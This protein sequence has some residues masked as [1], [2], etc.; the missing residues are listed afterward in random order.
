MFGGFSAP[1][2]RRPVATT[3]IMVAIFLVGLVAYPNLAVAPLPQVDFPTISVAASL[4][5]ASPETMAASVAQPLERQIAQIPG[6][7]QMTSTSGLGV[8]GITVQFDLNRNI[9]A[10]ANDIQAAI[11]AASGQLPKDLPSPPTYRKVNPSDTPILILSVQSDLKPIIDVDD[12]AENI[13]AQRISQISGVSLVRVGGQQTPAIRIQVDPAKLVE[14]GLQLED[15]RQQ[16]GIATVDSPKGALIGPRQTFTIYDNDQ[17]TAAKPWNDVIIAYRNGAPV[18]VRDIGRAVAGP[19]DTTQA[20]WSNGKSGV[21]LAIW[22]QPGANVIQTVEAVKKALGP[23]QAAIPTTIH[24]QILSDR[25]LTIRASVRDVQFTLMLTVGLVVMVIFIFLRNVWATVIPA[26]TIPL[27][28]LGACALMWAVGYSLDNLSLM[29]FTI[30]VGFVVDDA[31]VMLENITR[32]I[33]EGETPLQAA[34]KGSSEIGFTIISISVSLVAVLIP[35]IMM[36]GI[37]GR[38]FR[39]FSV[40]ITMTIAVSAFVALTLTPM[41][42]SRFLRS[43]DEERH[44]RLFNLGE[45]GFRALAHGYEH[46]LDFV[47]RHRFVTLMTFFA[48]VLATVYLFVA[49]PKGFFPQQD[50]GILYG[51]TEAAQDI[52]FPKMYRLQEEAGKIVQADPAVAAVGMGLGAGVGSTG[53]N[54]GRMFISLKPTDERNV[55]IFEVIARLRPKLA[56]IS[57]LRTYL[58]AAQDVTVGARF[59]KTQFQYTLLDVNLDELNAWAPKILDKLKSLPELRD[60]ATDQQNTGTTLTLKIDRDMASR[61]GIQPQLIDDT[62]YDAFGQREVAQYFTQVNTYWVVEEVLPSLRGDPA[63]L[64]K[65]YI[66]SPTT[67]QMVPLSVFAKWTTNPVAPLSISHQ[68]QFPAITISFNLANGVALSQ[69]TTAVQQAVQ[70]LQLPPSLTTTFQ[71]NAQAF[72]ELLTTVP[73]LILAALVCVYIILGILYESFVHPLTILSTLPSAGVGALATLM[74]FGYEFS[75]VALIGLILL[76]GIVKKN[77]IMMVDFAIAAEREEGK[78]T[79]EAIREAALLR[80]RPIMMTTMAALLGAVPLMLSHGSGSEMRQPLGFTMFGGL[81][82]SQA[83]TLFTTP[84]IYLYLD[85]VSHWLSR[86]SGKTRPPTPKRPVDMPPEERERDSRLKPVRVEGRGRAAERP[87]RGLH[88]V[89]LR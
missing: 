33:E 69:A 30:A 88:D 35:L 49:I 19:A 17:L 45:K 27:A 87:T 22:K 62:L 11:N 15:V 61:F 46:G 89:K 77:G 70:Q 9:D 81:I 82:F 83:L 8:T 43:Q 39:E 25:T 31:I 7:T 84:I 18:R 63:T 78:S 76:I 37:I 64:D 68:G 50:T 52:S 13:L 34:L 48:T 42:A 65:L 58:F 10:A 2:I 51:T 20:G 29:A 16:I 59:A 12:A 53:Q 6:V 67:G 1:F 74:L 66:R 85:R 56:Q 57:G 86:R 28:L 40:T 41:M 75:L 36:T 21:F 71:G 73:L 47:L 4:P 23:L 24:L 60:V 3:L 5:G 55:S 38:L 79:V 32:H 44:G 26:V 14:K 80:F 72:Q 54:M